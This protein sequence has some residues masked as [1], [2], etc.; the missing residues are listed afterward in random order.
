MQ[1]RERRSQ[2]AP[3]MNHSWT[4]VYYVYHSDIA[5]RIPCVDEEAATRLMNEVLAG[6]LAEELDDVYTI[7]PSV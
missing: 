2:C 7:G 1:P 3:V 6:P 5:T 4:V